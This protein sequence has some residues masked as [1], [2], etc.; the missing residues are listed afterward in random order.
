MFR[1]R[2]QFYVMQVERAETLKARLDLVAPQVDPKKLDRLN[3]RLSHVRFR[4]ALPPSRLARIAPAMVE[5]RAGRYRAYS[6]GF[7]AVIRDLFEPT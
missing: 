4:A 2:G 6:N 1:M 7:R 3:D 5:W